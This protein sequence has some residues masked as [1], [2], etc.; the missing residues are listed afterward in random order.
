LSNLIRWRQSQLP[1]LT[2]AN[3][4]LGDGVSVLTDS[5]EQSLT[6]TSPADDVSRIPVN[7]SRVSLAAQQPGLYSLNMA[8]QQYSFAVNALSKEESDLTSAK[9]GRWGKWQEANLFWWEYRS[10]DWLFGLIALALLTVHSL[11]TSRHL[12]E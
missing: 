11:L 2:Q 7:S 6:L 12:G 1:G 3:F 8:N 10:V 9:S 5:S 4:N